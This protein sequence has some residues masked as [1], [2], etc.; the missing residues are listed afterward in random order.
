MA[1]RRRPATDQTGPDA[2]VTAIR[3]TGPGAYLMVGE[4]GFDQEEVAHRLVAEFT[5]EKTRPFN[6]DLFRAEESETTAEAIAGA[7]MA[8]PVLA[9]VR[10]VIVRGLEAAREEVGSQ[11]AQLASGGLPSTVLLMLAGKLDARRKWVTSLVQQ[12]TVFTMSLPKGKA[13]TEWVQRRGKS[14]GVAMASDAAELLVEY[15]GDDLYRVASE[16]EKLAL[17]VSPRA[18]IEVADVEAVVGITCENTPYQLT[19][20]IA[21]SDPVGAMRIAHRLVEAGQ[22]PAYLVG[23][24]VRHWQTLRI[25]ADLIRRDRRG[26]VSELLGEN[27]P[28]LLNKYTAQAR[29]LPLE[30]IRTGFRLALAAESAIKGGWPLPEVILD[31][32]ICQ[33]AGQRKA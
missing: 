29:T 8:F 23:V 33:L 7:V 19:D 5:D 24:I 16:V 9:E 30:R 1:E 32:L 3:S 25:V 21:N 17:Y 2:I 18:G 22:H 15:L 10:V 20:C 26:N 6:Y 4:N 28:F 12:S 27:R 13:L 31:G 11:L 14:H